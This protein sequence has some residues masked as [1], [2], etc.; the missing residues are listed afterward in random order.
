M[1]FEIEGVTYCIKFYRQNT[2]YIAELFEV[3]LQATS[4]EGDEEGKNPMNSLGVFGIASL[5]YNDRFEKS[6][7]RKVALA[8]LLETLSD[9]DISGPIVMSKEERAMIWEKYFETHKK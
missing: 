2:T 6:V 7:G 3:N 8:K 9:S 5:Y 4:A 1:F